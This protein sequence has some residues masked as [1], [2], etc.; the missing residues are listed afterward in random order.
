M[1]LDRANSASSINLV[2]TPLEK[3]QHI[4][5]DSMRRAAWVA[6]E[7]TRPRQC[8]GMCGAVDNEAGTIP[9]PQKTEFECSL[10]QGWMARAVC[11]A[12]QAHERKL[13]ASPHCSCCQ[14]HSGIEEHIIRLCRS[15]AHVRVQ[16][17]DK[18]ISKAQ[19]I[20]L[21]MAPQEW[22][23]CLRSC[24]IMLA[25]CIKGSPQMRWNAL[26]RNITQWPNPSF[27]IGPSER[28]W[29]S[30]IGWRTKRRAPS[31]P[32]ASSPPT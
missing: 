24:K 27:R 16:H 20:R 9:L 23:G 21:P 26:W 12:R 17:W 14:A 7:A 32:L 5:R 13:Q 8:A 15:W 25:K 28:M 11:S 30:L 18:V 10:L 1:D 19:A 2:M 31:I 29:T 6:V 22:P 4:V 3:V